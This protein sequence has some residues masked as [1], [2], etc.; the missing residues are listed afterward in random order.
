MHWEKRQTRAHW[1]KE[2]ATREPITCGHRHRSKKAAQ[3][4]QAIPWR[5]LTETALVDSDS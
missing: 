5:V 3:G 4:C 1:E 2:Q